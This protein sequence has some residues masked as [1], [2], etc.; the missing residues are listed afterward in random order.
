MD[1]YPRAG[2]DFPFTCNVCGRRSLFQQTHYFDPETPSCATCGS[3][4]RL[5]WLI[6]RLSVEYFGRSILLPEFP[7]HKSIAGLG[8]TDSD[9][10][11]SVLANR[12]N[13]RNTFLTSEPR[14]DIRFDLSPL[15]ALDFLIASEVFEHVEPPVADAFDNAARLLKESG[16][17]LLTTPWVWEGDPATA[18]PQLYDWT[19]ER[20]E[21]GWSI[22]NRRGDDHVQ[23]FCGMSFDGSP[24]PSLGRTREHFPALSDW[25]LSSVDGEWRLRNDLP[26]GTVETFRNLV[27][28]GGPGLALEM[29][30]FTKG[31]IEENLRAAGFRQIEFEMQDTPEFGIVFGYPWSRPLT[32]RKRG[33]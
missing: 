6:L 24:G 28:H 19:L 22:V 3:N 18:I 26:D 20:D 14:F 21:T 1:Q 23:R 29:R 25:K 5:R 16:L 4:V 10:M 33:T 27:F 9:P 13:Y 31:G 11:A 2:P 17:L 12:F 15:G 8:L 30:L 32:A 7:A